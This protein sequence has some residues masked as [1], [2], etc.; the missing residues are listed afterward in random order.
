MITAAAKYGYTQSIRLIKQSHL[1]VVTDSKVQMIPKII[2]VA[3]S[4]YLAMDCM[5]QLVVLV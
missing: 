2:L 3:P 5:W 1:L 4:H